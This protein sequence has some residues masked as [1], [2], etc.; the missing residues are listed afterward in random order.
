MFSDKYRN[1]NYD[2]LF[3]KRF[4]I[5][6]GVILFFILFIQVRKSTFI[7]NTQKCEVKNYNTVGRVISKKKVKI[8]NIKSFKVHRYYNIMEGSGGKRQ[9]D[10]HYRQTVYAIPK[11]G[12]PYRFMGASDADLYH[13]AEHVVEE[14]NKI[15]PTTQAEVNI[16]ITLD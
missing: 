4:W 5:F 14:L 9:R 11:Y 1:Y 6:I 13:G 12:T 2:Y 10:T 8:E 3:D 15:V 16:N 7:C